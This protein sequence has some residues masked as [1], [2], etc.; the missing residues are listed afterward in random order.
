MLP[1]YKCPTCRELEEALH[2]KNPDPSTH[3]NTARLCTCLFVAGVEIATI[4]APAFGHET[5]ASSADIEIRYS[6]EGIGNPTK[7]IT[8]ATAMPTI[9]DG[10]VGTYAWAGTKGT[11]TTST[12][13]R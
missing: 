7:P 4:A 5:G 13:G 1:Q 11:I 12:A 10:K 6:T 9:I 3:N 8:N 2:A